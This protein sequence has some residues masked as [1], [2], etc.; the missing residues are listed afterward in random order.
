M[1]QLVASAGGR[2]FDLFVAKFRIQAYELLSY[3]WLFL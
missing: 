3:L 2:S 1:L